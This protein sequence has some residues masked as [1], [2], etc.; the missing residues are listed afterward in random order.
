[1]RGKGGRMEGGG[2]KEDQ[3]EGR[4]EE[5][6]G[7]GRGGMGGKL[8]LGRRREKKASEGRKSENLQK[9]GKVQPRKKNPVP[10]NYK[11]SKNGKHFHERFNIIHL[12]RSINGTARVARGMFFCPSPKIG[13]RFFYLFGGAA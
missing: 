6:K 5:G 3:R 2:E 10:E 12:L 13:H 8:E 4:R 9:V 7:G 1:M 11:S